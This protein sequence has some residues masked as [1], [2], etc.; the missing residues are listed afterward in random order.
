VRAVAV[1]FAVAALTLAGCSRG[2]YRVTA[3]FDDSG[4][5][6]TR[7]AVQVADVRVGT[8]GHIE[9]T[10]DFRSKV[11]M[12]IHSGTRIPRASLAL[13]R[14]TSLLG[15]RFVELRPEGDPG[16]GPWLADGDAVARTE[17]AAD[18]ESVAEQAVVVLGAVSSD[19]VARVVET[20]AEAVAGRGGDLRALVDDLAR[21]SATLAGR[22]AEITRII[23]SLG[24]ATA[25]LAGG[26][27]EVGALLAHLA[28]ASGVLADNRQRA[29]TALE[30][31]SRLARSQN[32]ILDRYRDDISRQV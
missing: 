27:D 11:T 30:Q 6:Q 19:D 22:T 20:G 3:V 2:S 4:D 26:S 14:T 21:V 8:I 23:D 1:A 15:E 7:G 18:L 24:H 12:D 29:V 16:A 25:T 31:L 10:R 17:E 5:L 32:V 9:L 28:A 13:L